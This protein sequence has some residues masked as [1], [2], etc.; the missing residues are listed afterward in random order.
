MFSL[1]R[2][3]GVVSGGKIFDFS[4]APNCPFNPFSVNITGGTLSATPLPAT[5]PLFMAGLA[6]LGLLVQ[7][8]RK[9]RALEPGS[10]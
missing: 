9:R 7:R 5:F 3:N 8:N 4:C 10:I 6:V 2:L 1:Q